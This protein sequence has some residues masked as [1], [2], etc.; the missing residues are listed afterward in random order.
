MQAQNP[1]SK[2]QHEIII[3]ICKNKNADYQS[4]CKATKRTRT[5][6]IQSLKPML[7]VGLVNKEKLNPSLV[8]SKL[9]FSPTYRGKAYAEAWGLGAKHIFNTETDPH[10]TNYLRV[11]VGNSNPSWHNLFLQ[12]LASNLLDM[13]IIDKQGNIELNDK[14]TALK[15]AFRDG[16]LRVIQEPNY[17]AATLFNSSTIEWL[18]K[19]FSADEVKEMK[20]ML[21]EIKKNSD[22]TLQI[23]SRL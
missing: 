6:I 12:E 10:I 13:S 23:L 16:L 15:E 5:T 20:M 4:I 2:L 19:L 14:I 3:H 21:L 11:L 8:K 9:I 7:K 17:D 22:S 18:K 1:Y